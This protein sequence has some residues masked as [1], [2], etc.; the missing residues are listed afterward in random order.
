MDDNNEDPTSRYVPAYRRA[1]FKNRNEFSNESVRRRRGSHAEEIRKVRRES[2]VANKRRHYYRQP[3]LA[4]IL[5][6]DD[7]DGEAVGDEEQ[8]RD[9]SDAVVV[10]RLTDAFKM[11]VD[12]KDRTALLT[13]V[14]RLRQLLSKEVDP[15]IEE[16]VRSGLVGWLTQL[17]GTQDE[18]TQ[19]EAAW[20]LTNIASGT[21]A[22][23]LA[24][25]RAGAIP[26]FVQL[27]A[28]RNPSVVEQAAWAIGN[29]AGDSERLRD[30]V[31]QHGG[32]TGIVTAITSADSLAAAAAAASSGP[33]EPDDEPKT[34]GTLKNAAWALTNLVRM[35]TTPPD[36]SYLAP[37]VPVISYLMRQSDMEIVSD[38]CWSLSY[39]LTNTE[40][41]VQPVV[42]S[43][44]PAQLL[45]AVETGPPVVQVPAL[46]AAGKITMGT[47]EQTNSLLRHGALGVLR[48][49]LAEGQPEARREACWLLSNVTAGTQPQIAQVVSSGVLPLVI[50]A[51]QSEDLKTRI[52]A[53]WAT[54]NLITSRYCLPQFA[55]YLF[56]LGY[57]PPVCSMLHSLDNDI[58]LMALE[59]IEGLLR[60]D[61]PDTRSYA[62]AV[63]QA[64]GAS[65]INEC[66]SFQNPAIS[67]KAEAI[68]ERYFPDEQRATFDD[69]DA[70]LAPRSQGSGSSSYFAF[71]PKPLSGFKFD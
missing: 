41:A 14:Q 20:S 50:A 55:G 21:S 3:G 7:D 51:M 10:S 36:W 45:R 18:E 61:D 68:M 22:Q 34:N 11:A 69:L 71:E 33:S 39:I 64:G 53:C 65:S 56:Q 19:F 26:R 47:A 6:S 28:S 40:Q 1:Q 29:I 25:A 17:L 67:Q 59:A 13:T 63:E 12:R 60:F 23:T 57:V 27:L 2:L 70:D 9:E 8:D 37:L 42:D 54:S 58:I 49:V 5:D 44:L 32:I 24:V 48:K 4:T 15:P 43:T 35:H 46:R 30:E 38:A 31:L 66:Q 62:V 16:V 52:E